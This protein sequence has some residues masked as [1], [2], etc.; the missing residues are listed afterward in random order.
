MTHFVPRAEEGSMRNLLLNSARAYAAGGIPVFPCKS[1]KSPLTRHGH[2][3]ATCDAKQ[4]VRLWTE[5]PDALIAI[6]TGERSG[7][8]VIDIDLK[9]GKDG[10]KSIPNWQVL[11]PIQVRTPSGGVHLHFSNGPGIPRSGKNIGAGIDILGEGKS[12]IMP[13][14]LGYEWMGS[15]DLATCPSFPQ[16]FRLVSMRARS[17]APVPATAEFARIAAAL[18]VIPNDDLSWDDWTY[19]GL[20]I[21]RATGGS[22]DGYRLFDWFSQKST[23]YDVVHTRERWDE[24]TRRPP[25][26]IGAGTLF[27]LANQTGRFHDPM[28]RRA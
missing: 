5:W 6:P 24:I 13:P 8:A 27:Y 23:K 16:Q 9:N 15:S 2:N 4:I 19:I 10:F 17:A 22:E 26:S 12:V 25:H 14:S 1:D 18:T 21:W 3:D 7:Q 28:K 20:A 11:S